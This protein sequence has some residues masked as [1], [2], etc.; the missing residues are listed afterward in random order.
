M[1]TLTQSATIRKKLSELQSALQEFYTA[2]NDAI[3]HD[4]NGVQDA[5]CNLHAIL[6][7]STEFNAAIEHNTLYVLRS[8]NSPW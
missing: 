4:I 5:D 3:P 1:P 2:V 6:E 8:K 7:Q